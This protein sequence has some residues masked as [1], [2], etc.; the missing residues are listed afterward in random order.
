V[1]FVLSASNSVGMKQSHAEFP[2]KFSMTLASISELRLAKN[3]VK[4][5]PLLDAARDGGGASLCGDK[6]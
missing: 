1:N 5:Q 4:A 6:R 3:D 2:N